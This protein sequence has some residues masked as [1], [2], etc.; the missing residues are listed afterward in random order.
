MEPNRISVVPGVVG[1]NTPTNFPTGTPPLRSLRG[2]T[3]QLLTEGLPNTIVATVLTIVIA[4]PATGEARL[5]GTDQWELGDAT[6]ASDILEFDVEKRGS[7][8]RA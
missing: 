3:I 8:I 5:V 1:A 6:I 4:A 2:A 7:V